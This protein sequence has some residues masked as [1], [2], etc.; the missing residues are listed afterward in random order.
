MKEPNEEL[1][2]EFSELWPEIQ[3]EFHHDTR[4][5]I[6]RGMEIKLKKSAAKARDSRSRHAIGY[7]LFYVAENVYIKSGLAPKTDKEIKNI[8]MLSRISKSQT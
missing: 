4:E 1:A 2:H 8:I 7:I 5:K 6:K 3:N